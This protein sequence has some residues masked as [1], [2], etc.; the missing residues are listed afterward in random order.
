MLDARGAGS[1]QIHKAAAFGDFFLLYQ[2]QVDRQGTVIGAE[3]L[4]RQHLE[5]RVF[6]PGYFIPLAEDTELIAARQ[7]I[8]CQ[9]QLYRWQQQR[10]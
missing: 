5:I 8:A 4:V 9:Q 3:A 1:S 2:P 10:V 6:W 7:Y